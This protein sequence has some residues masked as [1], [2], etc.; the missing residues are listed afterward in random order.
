[1]S[2]DNFP[3]LAVAHS[4]LAKKYGCLPS[5]ADAGKRDKY[6]EVSARYT[7]G[8]APLGKGDLRPV[9]VTRILWSLCGCCSAFA[10]NKKL[11]EGLPTMAGYSFPNGV[12]DP[13]RAS[14]PTF[15]V[16]A[17]GC[18]SERR[19]IARE[20]MARFAPEFHDTQKAASTFWICGN[21]AEQAYWPSPGDSQNVRY[22]GMTVNIK[23]SQDAPA[24]VVNCDNCVEMTKRMAEGKWL[25]H[26][27]ANL[28]SP[29]SRSV[30]PPVLRLTDGRP[31]VLR[32][33][34]GEKAHIRLVDG[35][36]ER[37]PAVQQ[38]V[39]GQLLPIRSEP[40]PHSGES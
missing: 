37:V 17:G 9:S 38:W 18:S 24:A 16:S 40:M 20:R 3:V 35:V 22:E 4:I 23:Q 25:L 32:M 15:G 29:T 6:W 21:C 34:N 1:M 36:P 28:R 11:R 27:R 13:D 12:N 26:D 31:A 2:S 30:T 39:D 8:T 7:L 14:Y 5:T 33:E 19:M 10:I